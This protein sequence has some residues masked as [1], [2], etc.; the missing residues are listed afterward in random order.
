VPFST[1]GAVQQANERQE[2]SLFSL[3]VGDNQLVAQLKQRVKHSEDRTFV[4][5]KEVIELKQERTVFMAK[6]GDLQAELDEVKRIRDN[7]KTV[8]EELR[9]RIEREIA[10]RIQQEQDK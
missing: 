8:I 4:L 5:E 10:M 7:Q 9:E 2:F 6:Q 1:G 3:N